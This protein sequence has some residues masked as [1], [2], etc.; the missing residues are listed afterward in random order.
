MSNETAAYWLCSIN[1]TYIDDG[2]WQTESYN[3]GVQAGADQ[4][5]EKYEK[6]CLEDD[7]DECIDLGKAAAEG[8]YQSNADWCIP[9]YISRP[10]H[11]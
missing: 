8:L 10:Y 6:Q 4:V 7:A 1:A 11:N 9:I 5:V 2:N 3:R